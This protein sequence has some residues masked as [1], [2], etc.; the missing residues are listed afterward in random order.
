[1]SLEGISEWGLGG[2][3][4][5]SKEEILRPDL[6][7]GEL[8]GKMENGCFASTGECE[9]KT[10]N[11]IVQM[12]IMWEDKRIG[13]SSQ[14][15]EQIEQLFGELTS[16][17]QELSHETTSNKTEV[18]NMRKSYE[19]FRTLQQAL[20]SIQEGKTQFRIR[21]LSPTECFRLQGFLNDEIDISNLSDTQCYKLA[22]NGQSL[23]VVTKIFKAMFGE[24]DGM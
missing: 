17:L 9:S 21:R 7:E 20:Y 5:L 11:T 3:S 10:V 8:Q 6:Y 13:C 24:E 4:T 15:Q 2:F 19:G 18:Q 23:N 1:M 12:R 14:R 22:G 16:A